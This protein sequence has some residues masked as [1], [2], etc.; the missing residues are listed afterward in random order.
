MKTFAH[1]APDTVEEACRLLAEYRGTA[2]INAGGTDLLGVLKD[3]IHPDYPKALVS[4]KSIPGL[5][6]IQERDGGLAIGAM[7]KLADVVKLAANEDLGLLASAARSVATPQIR[8]MG[9]VGGNLCQ[10][11]RCWYYR[12]PRHLGGPVSCLRKGG[13]TCPAVN[14]DNRYHAILAAKRCFAVC[15]SDLAVALT[16]LEATVAVAGPGGRRAIPVAELFTNLGIVLDAAEIVTE[17]RLA[18]PP[19]GAR[20]TFKKFAVRR[21]IDF[22][23]ASVA[24]VLTVEDGT[25]TGA[26]IALG[27]VAPLPLRAAVAEES[28][29]GRPVDEGTAAAAAEAAVGGARP[30]SK[31]A[32]KVSIMRALVRDALLDSVGLPG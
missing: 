16:A 30:L 9:T 5:D 6:G 8:A 3:D 31:N 4:L 14:G 12:Y 28:L 22:A 13:K 24:A 17:I 7:T 20:Q 27:G 15:P 18:R 23:V 26:R 11:V 25:C 1:H 21:P 19:V 32:Y 2:R 29:V 10:E